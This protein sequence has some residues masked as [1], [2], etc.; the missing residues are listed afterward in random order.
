LRRLHPEFFADCLL[1]F[2]GIAVGIQRNTRQRIRNRPLR[3][4]A[5]AQRI[6]VGRQLDDAGLVKPEF[7]GKLRNRFSRLVR[8]NGADMARCELAQ[9]I[10]C[11][12][13]RFDN[14]IGNK[15]AA[16]AATVF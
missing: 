2:E 9:R 15:K 12:L 3:Q 4:R 14:Q 1:Q 11:G 13:L 10:Q 7:S 6:L 5:D 16:A 8:G